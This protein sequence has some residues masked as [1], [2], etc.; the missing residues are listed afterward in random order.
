MWCD[1][2]LQQARQATLG[3]MSKLYLA[4]NRPLRHEEK[5]R[6]QLC[7]MCAGQATQKKQG[8]RYICFFCYCFFVLLSYAHGHQDPD[9][10]GHQDLDAH[11]HQDPDAHGHQDPDA[12]GHQDLSL[13]HI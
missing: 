7:L 10:H 8:L 9:A 2:A 12:H 6:A 11:V 5:R 4:P 3:N 13:I 1:T